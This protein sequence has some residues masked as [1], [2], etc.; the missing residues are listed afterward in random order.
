VAATGSVR[1]VKTFTYRGALRQFSNRYHIGT[2]VPP[3]SAH[4]NT[5]FDAI[6]AAEKLIY[7]P[8][9]AQG[10]T[11]VEAV[12][13]APG[14]EVPVATK[15]YSLAGTGSF[16]AYSACPG[17]AAALVRFS[18]PDRSTKNHPV[19][20]FNYFHAVGSA[21]STGAPDTVCAQQLTAIQTY[22][23]AWVTGFSDGV[24][25]YK[26]SRPTGDLCTA[27]LA[28]SLITHRDLP[29]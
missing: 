3:D 7:V 13:Y 4:W 12:G 26:R 14:S 2:S 15:A 11:I 8:P 27:A 20:C 25:T 29:R 10:A 9:A 21:A 16:S 19:Y 5:L 23:S 22:A 17:D 28:E 1:I 18:T 6:T 24:T